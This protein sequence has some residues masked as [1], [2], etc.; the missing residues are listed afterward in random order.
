MVVKFRTAFIP[1]PPPRDLNEVLPNL[2]R[3]KV[4]LQF[5][6]PE[7]QPYISGLDERRFYEKLHGTSSVLGITSAFHGHFSAQV[8]SFGKRRAIVAE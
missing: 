5:K 7:L 3:D 4:S 2:L 1:R 6:L 8:L